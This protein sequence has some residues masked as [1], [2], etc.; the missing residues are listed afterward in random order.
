MASVL[1]MCQTNINFTEI[2]NYAPDFIL[3]NETDLDI[4]NATHNGTTNGTLY[5]TSTESP[6]TT[7]TMDTI[8]PDQV[9]CTNATCSN[10]TDTPPCLPPQDLCQYFAEDFCE[11]VSL[12]ICPIG[13]DEIVKAL[14][15][16]TLPMMREKNITGIVNATS[17][18]TAM[19]LLDGNSTDSNVMCAC[20]YL[21]RPEVI[22][23]ITLTFF[24]FLLCVIFM[25]NLKVFSQIQTSSFYGI[26]E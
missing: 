11:S 6:L 10:T 2:W 5:T 26:N 22:G 21:P 3:C 4:G 19:D 9:N 14:L 20:N 23:K 7:P 16:E 17:D 13:I 8:G 18:W 24:L 25:V 1:E 15:N 12:H